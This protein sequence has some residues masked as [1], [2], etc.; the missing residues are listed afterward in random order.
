[1]WR[2]AK[3]TQTWETW[4]PPELGPPQ[5]FLA[6][7]QRPG[8]LYA[9]NPGWAGY[10][11]DGGRTWT[12]IQS[13]PGGF[14]SLSIAPNGSDLAGGNDDGAFASSDGGVTWRALPTGRLETKSVAIAPSRPS[15]IYRLTNP[16]NGQQ[17]FRRLASDSGQ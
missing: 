15:T 4:T 17:L 6:N 9:A 14:W 7:P 2:F 5:V 10:S 3:A 8:W 11:T 13:V 1:M 12:R 16:A